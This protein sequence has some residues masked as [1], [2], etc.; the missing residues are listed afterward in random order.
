MRY[1]KFYKPY[2][3]LTQFTDREGRPTLQSFIPVPTASRYR[4][5]WR[6]SANQALVAVS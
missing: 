3:V 4:C 2:G 6:R 5:G 1:L